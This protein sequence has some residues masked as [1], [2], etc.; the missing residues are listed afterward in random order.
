MLRNQ[1]FPVRFGGLGSTVW[2]E[3]G[4]FTVHIYIYYSRRLID[5]I[6]SQQLR[7][8]HFQCKRSYE[9]TGLDLSYLNL[10]KWALR[11]L[12]TLAARQSPGN[13]ERGIPRGQFRYEVAAVGAFLS[14]PLQGLQGHLG[15]SLFLTE[16]SQL[17]D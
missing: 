17:S 2:H 4:S 11:E 12:R 13:G 14:S 10:S 8:E 15:A 16:E 1:S 5:I 3:P 6:H 9:S 7:G